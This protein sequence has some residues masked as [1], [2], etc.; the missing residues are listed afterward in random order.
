MGVTTPKEQFAQV[1]SMILRGALHEACDEAQAIARDAEA[2]GDCLSWAAALRDEGVTRFERFEYAAAVLCFERAVELSVST[3]DLLAQAELLSWCAVTRAA[4]DALVPAR[5]IAEQALNALET[6]QA[7]HPGEAGVSAARSRA[8]VREN[9]AFVC[10]IDSR[11]DQARTLATQAVAGRKA[12]LREDDDTL[13]WAGALVLLGLIEQAAHRLAPA[14]DAYDAALE[15]RR[16]ILGPRH[17][18]VGYCLHHQ[19][20]I[21]LDRGLL[22]A[23][24][25][26]TIDA[27]EIVTQALGQRHPNVGSVLA[28]LA[29]IRL[30]A[31]NLVGGLEALE[32][33][34]DVSQRSFGQESPQHGVIL[35]LLGTAQRALGRAADAV[36]TLEAA[37]RMLVP[38]HVSRGETLNNCLLSL[39]DAYIE[40]EMPLRA[41]TFLG[42]VALRFEAMSG[43]DLALH[44]RVV[45]GNAVAQIATGRAP[46]ALEIVQPMSARAQA[47]LGSE[48]P[49]SVELCAAEAAALAELG[50]LDEAQ[51]I[52]QR[53]EK[54]GGLH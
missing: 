50:R 52:L 29:A 1:R 23:A 51:V 13:E 10:W 15:A 25:A 28:T 3:G 12:L 46:A 45:L 35:L 5:T 38:A 6:D 32:R 47:A 36:D 33:A 4:D 37:V 22:D 19:A 17:G 41:V 42:E 11:H 40:A 34:L 49:L 14:T 21:E 27:L 39:L 48:S 31:G 9:L 54:L 24:E 18:Y 44:A 30:E 8:R 7:M 26:T 16:R 53:I 43:V 2:R 20:Q